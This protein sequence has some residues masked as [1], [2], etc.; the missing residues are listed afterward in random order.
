[1]ARVA[2]QGLHLL[3]CWDLVYESEA[4]LE[5]LTHVAYFSTEPD[6]AIL[7]LLSMEITPHRGLLQRCVDFCVVVR[8]INGAAILDEHFSDR[9]SMRLRLTERPNHVFPRVYFLFIGFYAK[10][11]I[12]RGGLERV[13]VT[14][15]GHMF[16]DN[17]T[18]ACGL[19]FTLS[20][21]L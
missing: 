12:S 11:T 7:A 9:A 20:K 18:S 1:M 4:T 3:G 8:S 10:A 15:C 5:G 19:S 2:G 16:E 17:A 13:H 14:P 21:A 6:G